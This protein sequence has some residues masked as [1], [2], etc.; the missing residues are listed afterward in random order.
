MDSEASSTIR[1][2]DNNICIHCSDVNDGK[3]KGCIVVL[4]SIRKL[5]STVSHKIPKSRERCFPQEDGEYTVAVFRQNMSN[6]LQTA[7]LNVSVVSIRTPTPTTCKSG[8]VKIPPRFSS[9]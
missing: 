7:P 5:E 9:K 2:A 6:V 8:E 1:V 3:W 4:H